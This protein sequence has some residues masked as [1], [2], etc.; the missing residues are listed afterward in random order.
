MK[1][2]FLFILAIGFLAALYWF[3]FYQET[4]RNPFADVQPIE[5]IPQ[6][7][8]IIL[9]FDDYYLM[10]HN[11]AKMPFADDM[12]GAFFVKKMSEDF[13]HFRKLF[14]KNKN[15]RQLLLD[16]P[17]TAALHLSG[18][19]DVDF[20]YIL[21]D[22][23]SVF[24]L[25]NLLEKFPYRKSSSNKNVVY[26]LD[27]GEGVK[28]T[29]A[30]Y[31]DLLLI[32][33]YA[34]LVESAL[35]Q[36]KSPSTNLLENHRLTFSQNRKRIENQIEL[37]ILFE[38]LKS[39]AN[40]FLNKNAVQNLTYFSKYIS[41]GHWVLDFEKE[42]VQVNGSIKVEE[43]NLMVRNIF[44]K[45]KN[46]NSRATDVLPKN[47][48]YFL[49]HLINGISEKNNSEK[50]SD[51][52]FTKYFQ[53]WVGEECLTGRTEIFTR[54]MRAERFV[55]YQIKKGKQKT[56]QHYL[57]LLTDSIGL[58]NEWN[59]QTYS[60]KQVDTKKM[61]L[62][63][64]QNEIL[65]FEK[66]C[67]TFIDDF[68]VFA[69]AGRILENW[70]DYYLTNQTLASYV[71]YLKMNSQKEKN[72]SVEFYL[73]I[74]QA[75][76][77]FKNS[78]DTKNKNATTQIDLWQKFLAL[79]FNASFEKDEI[80]TKGFLFYEKE[81]KEKVKVKWRTPLQT[82][83][84]TQPYSFF[85]DEKGTYDILI[86]DENNR[87]YLLNQDGELEWDILLE[88]PIQSKI[89]A[90][91]F[92][93]NSSSYYLFNTRNK[94]YLIDFEGNFINEFPLE[95]S[96]PASNGLMLADFGDN[97]FGFFIAC[98]NQ[99]LYG[100]DKNGIPLTGW[101]SVEG[102]GEILQSMKHFQT[103]KEDFIIAHNTNGDIFSFGKDGF[104]ATEIFN[105]M[106]ESD[107]PLCFQLAENKN[108]F[109]VGDKNESLTIL[110]LDK[111]NLNFLQNEISQQYI[112]KYASAD[113]GG[114]NLID[115]AVLKN[116]EL[117]ILYNHQG[118][119]EVY[120]NY[121]FSNFQDDIFSVQSKNMGKSMLG[122]LCKKQ[123]QIFLLDKK[124][125]LQPDFP[126]AGSTEF[127]LV[128]LFSENRN[129]ILVADG[130][131]VVAYEL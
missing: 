82:K 108:Q 126:L 112:Y 15:H 73:G 90:V 97:D 49:S 3:F 84:I 130:E 125:K 48:A 86:Q 8:P 121:Q 2:I 63:F 33:K 77:F 67:Y 25:Q 38:N 104:V 7:T 19:S 22:N 40:P 111:E 14:F 110:N 117:K 61:P 98:E 16:S 42:G 1:K 39:F 44:S 113:I 53:P 45:S 92:F 115:F 32:S 96:S 93:E 50:P 34:Y 30:Y 81:N 114:D 11:I 75:N 46:S 76:Q 55:A 10:R 23:K 79:G 35:Q 88:T 131:Q 68:V 87:L 62:P 105:I 43:N 70:I 12:S 85:N 51:K 5:A 60:I 36:L 54:K 72:G 58:S 119:F 118:G 109:V 17:V 21:K 106:N 107:S 65:N 47:T 120:G 124:G 78:F 24:N 95:L 18:K 94:I 69:G 37:T 66:P 6:N 29:I 128:N 27:L 57:Q 89:L 64:T 100:F 101:N 4:Y 127:E 102:A 13:K 80:L 103:E 74:Q 99:L 41:S 59:Y 116:K 129:A 20:L 56:A 31:K 52:I 71:P 123:N 9:E 28:Y 122:T 91:D 26:Q 83:A